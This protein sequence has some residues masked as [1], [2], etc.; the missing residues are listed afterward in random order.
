MRR[1]LPIR[2][3]N[4]H[5]GEG[6]EWQ[7]RCECPYSERKAPIQRQEQEQKKVRGLQVLWP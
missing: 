6:H 5:T 2:G 3:D 7:R 4:G 1:Y